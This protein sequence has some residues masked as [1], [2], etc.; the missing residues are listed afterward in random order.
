MASAVAF[1]DAVFVSSSSRSEAAGLASLFLENRGCSSKPRSNSI[2]DSR[3]VLSR[4]VANS[5]LACFRH[6][7]DG[8]CLSA[9]S[10]TSRQCR[11]P[12]GR[13]RQCWRSWARGGCGSVR[14]LERSVAF[15]CRQCGCS[16]T[17]TAASITYCGCL[18]R[19]FCDGP[20]ARQAAAA[21]ETRRLVATAGRGAAA[22]LPLHVREGM[23]SWP[24]C[25][26][27]RCK[28]ATV[29]HPSRLGP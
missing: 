15:S 14:S 10:T 26:K 24:G 28:T 17:G 21:G 16:A 25:A 12:I 2:A 6:S 4:G 1:Y 11:S 18:W 7:C 20:A 22:S 9:Y 19:R 8:R 23:C 27:G 13:A 29:A 5:Q 3:F